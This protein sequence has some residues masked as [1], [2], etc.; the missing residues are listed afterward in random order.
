MLATPLACHCFSDL[1]Y[2]P[3]L[4]STCTECVL[5]Q[6]CLLPRYCNS[7]PVP[8]PQLE[9]S[10]CRRDFCPFCCLFPQCPEQ[11]L[12]DGSHSSIAWTNTRTP[13]TLNPLHPANPPRPHARVSLR[14]K[15]YRHNSTRDQSGAFW[16]SYTPVSTRHSL[17][18]TDFSHPVKQKFK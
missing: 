6:A 10:S 7:L 15:P 13:P 1:I 9:W 17:S 8:L 14:C 4:T 11:R 18:L 3:L 2:T 12:A 16:A 5:L